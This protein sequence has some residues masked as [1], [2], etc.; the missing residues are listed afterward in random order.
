MKPLVS[1]VCPFGKVRVF[2]STLVSS[3]CVLDS[4]NGVVGRLNLVERSG[5]GEVV[6]VSVM[7]WAASLESVRPSDIRTA[8]ESLPCISRS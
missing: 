7:L 5:Q 3:L 4:L 1:L 2:Q 8:V 6:E